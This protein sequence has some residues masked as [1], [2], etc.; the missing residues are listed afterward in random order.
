MMYYIFFSQFSFF[1]GVYFVIDKT[2]DR[3]NSFHG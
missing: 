3:R 1:L 2:N